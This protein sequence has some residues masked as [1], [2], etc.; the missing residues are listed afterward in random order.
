MPW[1]NRHGRPRG[2]RQYELGHR[3]SW[4]RTPALPGE[5]H[6]ANGNGQ[7]GVC[8]ASRRRQ[9]LGWKGLFHR[10]NVFFCFFSRVGAYLVSA[11]DSLSFRA[12]PYQEALPGLAMPS[13]SAPA[14]AGD[15]EAIPP[16]LP[17]WEKVSAAAARSVPGT[18][19]CGSPAVRALGVRCSGGRSPGRRSARDAEPGSG[20]R[21]TSIARLSCS[22]RTRYR[23]PQSGQVR[24]TFSTITPGER[25]RTPWAASKPNQNDPH[26]AW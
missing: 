10:G 7:C 3:T 14:S 20:R 13:G 23:S 12:P 26:Q 24:Q 5:L 11:G 22:P 2:A 1:V 16:R 25:S 9:A 19:A 8:A 6:H 21:T 18:Q 15:Q 17:L 4:R